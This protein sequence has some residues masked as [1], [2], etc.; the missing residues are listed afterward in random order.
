[1]STS[2]RARPIDYPTS[3]GRPMAETDLHRRLMMDLIETLD[4]RFAND[5]RVYVSGD[6][7]LFYE[8][9]NGR[10]HLAPDVFVV[11]GIEKKPRDHYLMWLEGKGPDVVIEVTSKT[12]RREDQTNKRALYQDVLRVPEYFQID[13]TEDYLKP[14]FQGHRLVDGRYEPIELIDGRLP[15]ASLGLLLERDGPRLHLIDPASG[16]RLPTPRERAS[17]AEARLA[18]SESEN[19]RLRRELEDL[20]RRLGAQR[21]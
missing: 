5:P 20:R 9:S 21:E 18:A 12:T 17:A 15:S 1:M 11:F 13:P 10:K 14:P 8:E 6:L 3:D 7:L 4:E 16:L 2:S 19:D